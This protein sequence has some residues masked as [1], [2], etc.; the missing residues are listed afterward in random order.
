[1][2]LQKGELTLTDCDV[3]DKKD[4]KG[5]KEQKARVTCMPHVTFLPTS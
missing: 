5:Q 2:K 4:K 1:M 3:G